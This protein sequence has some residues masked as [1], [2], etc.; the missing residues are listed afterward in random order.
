LGFHAL[1][2][3][4]VKQP[5]PFL[6]A[7]GY[8]LFGCLFG[9]LSLLV[10]GHHLTPAGATRTLNLILTPIA[11]GLIMAMLGRWRA[12][13]GEEV[14]RLDRFAYGYLFALGLALIRFKFAS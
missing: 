2:A 4:F 14:L 1:A 13:R 8:L 5:N 10:I 3:P 7:F 9:G 12:R 6:A 11:C